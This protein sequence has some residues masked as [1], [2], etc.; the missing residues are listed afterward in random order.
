[1]VGRA[2]EL[3]IILWL[4]IVGVDTSRLGTPSAE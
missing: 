1:M 3:P 4:L 2:G